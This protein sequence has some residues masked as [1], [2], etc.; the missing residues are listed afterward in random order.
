MPVA[1]RL[2]CQQWHLLVV[3]GGVELVTKTMP[4]ILAVP[5]GE[6]EQYPWLWVRLLYRRVFS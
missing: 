2:L 6:E 3:G 4:R 1:L 5:R